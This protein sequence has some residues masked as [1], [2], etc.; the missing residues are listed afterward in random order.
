MLFT[1][2]K[3]YVSPSV[4]RHYEALATRAGVSRSFLARYALEKALPAVEEYVRSGKAAAA[5]AAE[6]KLARER[7]RAP[8]PEGSAPAAPVPDRKRLAASLEQMVYRQLQ[9]TPH[10]DPD[11]L[12]RLVGSNIEAILG[13]PADSDVLDEAVE[14][15]VSSR[16]NDPPR[17]VGG[18]RPPE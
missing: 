6:D 16:P 18:N 9:E 8:G 13:V 2:V 15:I 4:A 11:A 14:R 7:R 5:R 17:P 3:F 1:C 12:R 10:L